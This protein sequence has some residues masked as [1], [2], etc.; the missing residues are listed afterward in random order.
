VKTTYNY[1][2]YCG[3]YCGACDIHVA[4]VTGRKSRFAS[5]FTKSTL[6]ALISMRGIPFQ[7]AD[8]ELK[9]HGCKTGTLFIN[10]SDCPIRTCAIAKKVEHCI[11]CSDYPCKILGARKKME[12]MLPHL[13]TNHENM[14]MIRKNGLDR[15]LAEQDEKWKCPECRTR[16]SWY[17]GRCASCGRD[18]RKQAFTLSRVKAA[19]LKSLIHLSSF[20]QIKSKAK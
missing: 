3:I 15:W 17:A 13:T 4:Y 18:L 8:L 5:F 20:A 7:P 12:G 11:D 19:F 14:V 2:S 6:K 16:F 1:D 9:C 10:C